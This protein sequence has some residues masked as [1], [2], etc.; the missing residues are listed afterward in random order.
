VFAPGTDL[1]TAR[2]PGED[3]DVRAEDFIAEHVLLAI[4]DTSAHPDRH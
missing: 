3:G 4:G 1:M 2:R